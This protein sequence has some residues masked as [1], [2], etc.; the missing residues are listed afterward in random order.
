M[1]PRAEAV[2][3]DPDNKHLVSQLKTDELALDIG[4]TRST[5]GDN[6]T[7]ATLGRDGDIVVDG[8][9]IAKIQCSFEIDL[10]T[11]V[12]MFYDR[13]HSQTSQVLGQNATPFEYGRPRKIVVQ[14]NV[15]TIIGFGGVGRNLFQFE[16]EWHY[17]APETM[18]IVKNRASTTL[19]Y[20]ENP[21]LAQT[22]DITDTVLPSK[23]ET[24]LN[25]AGPQLTKLRYANLVL[26]GSGQFGVVYKAVNLDSGKFLAVKTLKRPPGASEQE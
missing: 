1:N 3:A 13:S 17:D 9:S 25:T 4:H 14:D 19:G 8:R 22:V 18:E 20:E 2:L 6:T 23:R 5:S 11:K 10:D 15:N 16:L 12:V 26:L 7:I 21:R 24:R